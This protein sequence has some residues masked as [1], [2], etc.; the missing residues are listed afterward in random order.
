MNIMQSINM[1]GTGQNKGKS[2]DISRV[3][4]NLAGVE[5]QQEKKSVLQQILE[6][7]ETDDGEK[8]RRKAMQIA[9]KIARGK[10]VTPEEK[11]FLIKFDPQLAEMAEL[12]GKEYQRIK[13]AL[14]QA[15]TKEEQ[16]NIVH[17]SYLMVI[18]VSKA[19]EQFGMLL[20]E[21]VKEAV[22]ES[23]KNSAMEEL[24]EREQH[25][26][27]NPE[28]QK[29]FPEEDAG[30]MQKDEQQMLLEQFFPEARMS[31]LDCRR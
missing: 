31:M 16:Q 19:N 2:V 21:A 11:Q 5:R 6:P 24:P 20:G 13:N 9:R 17:Q 29:K 22:Q 14:S 25:S 3:F 18:Q 1:E 26:A 10:S 23:Q 8:E 27:E 4:R 28:Q 30:N 12:A 7:K 15:S